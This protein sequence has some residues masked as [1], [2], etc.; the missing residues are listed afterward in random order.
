MTKIYQNMMKTTNP[1]I[2]EF[3]KHQAG[4]ENVAWGMP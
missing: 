3:H 2:Q 1:Q 4:M